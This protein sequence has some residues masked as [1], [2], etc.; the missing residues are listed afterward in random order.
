MAKWSNDLKDLQQR[1]KE[2]Q[3]ARVHYP[4]PERGFPDDF[5]HY[6][7]GTFTRSADGDHVFHPT[8][9]I[10]QGYSHRDLTDEGPDTG[11]QDLSHIISVE[12]Y[13]ELL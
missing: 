13:V 6:M 9:E 11:P 4:H 3:E 7:E 5:D 2:G 10:H 1:I 8:D 12:A